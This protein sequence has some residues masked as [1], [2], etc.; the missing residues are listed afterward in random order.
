MKR[1]LYWVNPVNLIKTWFTYEPAPYEVIKSDDP[2]TVLNRCASDPRFSSD[3]VPT[4]MWHD[5]KNAPVEDWSWGVY[6]L[7]AGLL[8]IWI[9]FIFTS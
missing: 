8:V 1:I 7:T 4:S 3:I 9:H 6:V 2:Q 5:I